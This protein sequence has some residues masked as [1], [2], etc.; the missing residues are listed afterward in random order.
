MCCGAFALTGMLY[1]AT[2]FSLTQFGLA[3][4]DPATLGWSVRNVVLALLILAALVAAA[5]TYDGVPSTSFGAVLLGAG[6]AWFGFG[7]L[8]MHAFAV[9]S[10]VHPSSACACCCPAGHGSLLAD[11]A[12]HGIGLIAALAGGAVL[13]RQRQVTV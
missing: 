8:D 9:L 4:T 6:T 5:A 12:F 2:V 13:V 1:M 11:A 7:V 3:S 10:L